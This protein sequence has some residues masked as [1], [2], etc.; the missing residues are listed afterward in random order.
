MMLQPQTEFGIS[1]KCNW[2]EYKLPLHPE[3]VYERSWKSSIAVLGKQRHAQHWR[4]RWASWACSWTDKSPLGCLIW[5]RDNKPGYGHATWAAA[6]QKHRVRV[7]AESLGSW[8]RATWMPKKQLARAQAPRLAEF[9]LS[10]LGKSLPH[11]GSCR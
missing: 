6:L 2:R 10:K 11:T 1:L 4:S 7:T 8:S 5:A 3:R 9:V